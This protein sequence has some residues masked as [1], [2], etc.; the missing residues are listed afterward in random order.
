[1]S[2][3]VSDDGSGRL[4]FQL[5]F[6]KEDGL[7]NSGLET[8]LW[9]PVEEFRAREISGWRTFGSLTGSGSVIICDLAPVISRI[10]LA[11]SRM[12]IS[13]GLPMFTGS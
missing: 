11:K 5:F 12:V 9:L 10:L 4:D 7:P 2:L 1:M 6:K 8:N 13:R 3:D